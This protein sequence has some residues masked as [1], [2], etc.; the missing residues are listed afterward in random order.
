VDVIR[1]ARWDTLNGRYVFHPSIRCSVGQLTSCFLSQA[2]RTVTQPTPHVLSSTTSDML[3]IVRELPRMCHIPSQDSTYPLHLHP[4]HYQYP[5]WHHLHHN[6][7][8]TM[9]KS[10]FSLDSVRNRITATATIPESTRLIRTHPHPALAP[11]L[12]QKLHPRPFRPRP[13]L[14]PS[15]ASDLP[16]IAAAT[17]TGGSF[18]PW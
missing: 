10:V 8:L 5:Q 12:S 11:F 15:L 2:Q 6:S 17:R 18:L 7:S 3:H 1:C 16:Q 13:P 9:T 14:P 4:R